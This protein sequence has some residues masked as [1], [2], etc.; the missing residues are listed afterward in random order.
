MS[1]HLWKCFF[2]DDV[3]AFRQCLAG[4]RARPGSKNGV[5]NTSKFGSP[6]YALASSPKFSRSQRHD[7]WTG[8]T[9]PTNRGSSSNPSGLSRADLNARDA[10]GR[11][12][13]HHIASSQLETAFDF[14][15]ALLEVASIDLYAQDTE[16]GWT[17]LHRALYFGNVAVASALM[18]RDIRDAT[19]FGA[20][21][22][23]QHVGGLIKIKDREG[24]GPFD[25]YNVS[26]AMRDRKYDE[27][28]IFTIGNAD[29]AALSAGES[30]DSESDLDDTLKAFQR[31]S[32]RIG[33]S[34]D[35]DEV[36]TFGRYVRGGSLVRMI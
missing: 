2:E 8:G 35:G 30:S 20:S 24:N 23:N 12:L 10:F 14:A 22:Q 16:N 6:G 34:L 21:S 26:T 13:L 5:N 1:S 33:A 9:P 27:A 18:A 32:T 19:A 31:G 11:T 17:A 3:D 15:T 28:D 4:A 7:G 25:L 29:D 36:Y